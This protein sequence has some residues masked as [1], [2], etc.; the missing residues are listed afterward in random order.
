MIK[1]EGKNGFRSSPYNCKKFNVQDDSMSLDNATILIDGNNVV[2]GSL[3]Y[4]WK[5]LKTLLDWLDNNKTEWFLYFDATIWYVKELEGDGKTYIESLV[6][7]NRAKVC[8]SRTEADSFILLHADKTGSHIISNDG[9]KKWESKYPWIATR[10]G[11][12]NLRVHKFMVVEDMLSIPDVGIWEKI[13][14]TANNATG[15]EELYKVNKPCATEKIA[16]WCEAAEWA[17]ETQV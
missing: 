3:R 12:G 17:E 15:S 6:D 14:A 8:P 9:Y 4:G 11:T 2:R 10:T 16:A 5:V 13:G 1:E 7:D